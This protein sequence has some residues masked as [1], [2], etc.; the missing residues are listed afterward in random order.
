MEIY[1]RVFII[2]S[3]Q[4]GEFK[5][6]SGCGNSTDEDRPQS[7]QV[8]K[9]SIKHPGKTPGGN[10]LLKK[11]SLAGSVTREDID[12]ASKV[13]AHET[14]NRLAAMLIKSQTDRIAVHRSDSSN[15]KLPILN[16]H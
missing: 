16:K 3:G 10:T 13:Y 7:P 12:M 4:S 9:K 14:R 1:T 15:T 6:D 2:F 5:G 8:R 11:R